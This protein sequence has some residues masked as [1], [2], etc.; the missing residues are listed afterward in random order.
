MRIVTIAVA[1]LISSVAVGAAELPTSKPASASMMGVGSPADTSRLF[2]REGRNS[3]IF[4]NPCPDL[5]ECPEP[6]GETRPR[7]AYGLVRPQGISDTVRLER[8]S[9]PWSTGRAAAR[10]K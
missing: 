2:A 5:G 8:F 4:V 1:V 6:F 9:R 10:H 3:L 7:E